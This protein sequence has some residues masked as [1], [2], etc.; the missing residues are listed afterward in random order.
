MHSTL[1]LGRVFHQRIKP[2][3][4]N[5]NYRTFSVLIN[6]DELE[7]INKLL[8]FSVNS[9]NLFSFHFKDHGKRIAS[10]N[11]KDFIKEK[12]SSKFKD[13]KKYSIYLYCTPRFLGYVFNPIS[14]YL[15]KNSKNEIKYICYE[16]KNTQHEQHSYFLKITNKYE[17]KST[18]NLI[19]NFMFLRFYKCS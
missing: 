13:K 7:V 17:I 9:S 2:I 16:V 8:F 11:P 14:V 1:H 6:L 10:S 5:F 18:Q 3:N 4:Y 19:K 15:C 12:I